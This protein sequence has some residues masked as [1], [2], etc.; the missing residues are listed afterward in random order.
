MIKKLNKYSLIA[1]SLLLISCGAEQFGVGKKTSSIST[2]PIVTGTTES[3]SDYTLVRPPVDLLFI[4]DNS[5]S[6]RYINSST[7]TA[8]NNTINY[9][10]DRFDYQVF[11]APL[12]GSGNSNTFFFSRAGHNPSGTT[13]ISKESASNAISSFPPVPGGAEYGARRARDLIRTNISNGIFRK[14]AFTIIIVMS[15]E[16][17][18]SVAGGDFGQGASLTQQYA[19]ADGLSHDLLCLKGNYS[20]SGLKNQNSLYSA[21]CSG[22]TKLNSSMMRFLTIAPSTT[23]GEGFD[24][25]RI[26]R[27]MS[28][29]I[30]SQQGYSQSDYTDICNGNYASI[31]DQVNSVIADKVVK[32]RYNFWPVAGSGVSLDPSTIKVFKDNGSQLSSGQFTY[33]GKKYN[34]DTRYYPSSGE[35]YTGHMIQLHGS[36]EVTFPSCLKV[37]YQGP[38]DYYGYCHIPSKPLASSIE[39]SVNGTL[40]NSSK[41]SLE[42]DSSG[43]PKYFSNKNI[44]ITSPSNFTAK[45]PAK[46][47]SGYF[48]RLDSSA[49]YSNDQTCDVRYNTAG[50]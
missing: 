39:V 33:V 11:M 24:T 26:Y 34:K 28:Q 10:S 48:I 30:S 35:P 4:W 7:K 45:T 38:K 13:V 46:Y 2:T 29:N 43:N 5:T 14:E 17:D 37:D 27:R 18:N 12:K 19:Y 9:I 49:V 16:D 21:N 44:K 20:S 42:L 3:C 6:T 47:E 8:L 22:V 15:N 40:L 25:N 31:F 41:W 1:L 36:A 50:N 32:H 23:C